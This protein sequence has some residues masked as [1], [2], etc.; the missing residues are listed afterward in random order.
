MSIKI[1]EASPEDSEEICL[2]HCSDVDHWYKQDGDQKIQV[3]YE[4]LTPIEHWRQ[5]GPWMDLGLCRQY[6]KNG[7]QRLG[8]TP[9]IATVNNRCVG[10]AEFVLC[11]EPEPYFDFGYLTTI[12]VHKDVRRRGIGTKLVKECMK[13]TA[14]AGLR[15]FDTVPEGVAL[16]LYNKLGMMKWKEFPVLS[17]PINKRRLN[18]KHTYTEVEK[19]YDPTDDFS[20]II[21]HWY[22]AKYRWTYFHDEEYRR[23]YS[24]KKQKIVQ[25]QLENHEVIVAL[26]HWPWNNTAG[27]FI[28]FI[29][30]YSP[31]KIKELTQIVPVVNELSIEMDFTSLDA[32]GVDP[33]IIQ[34]ED[35]ESLGFTGQPVLKKTSFLYLRGQV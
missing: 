2:I 11:H 12:V 31:L 18:L 30:P 32:R 10:E 6:L 8:I 22:P 15:F 29:N 21:D 28:L 27:R 26:D 17:L 23:F 34:K 9:L 13:R 5:G 33:E 1:R 35:L 7:I 16:N 24:A 14:D 20:V 25:M 3:Q 19:S 4:E